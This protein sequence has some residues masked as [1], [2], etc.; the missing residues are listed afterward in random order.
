MNL[1]KL[2]RAFR[3]EEQCRRHLE[4]MRWPHGPRCPKCEAGAWRLSKR[5]LYE[6]SV[7]HYQFSVLKGTI[8][9]RTHL[10]LTI[11]FKVIYLMT[12]SKKGISACQIKRMFGIHYRT[13]WYLCHRIRTAMRTSDIAEKLMGVLEMD[14]TYVGGK[15]KGVGPG[16][17]GAKSKKTPVLGI[18]ERGGR[19]RCKAV[20][21]VSKAEVLRFAQREMNED[22]VEVL[23]TDEFRSYRI[24]SKIVPH[25]VINHQISYVEG[26]IHTNTVENFWSL[27]KR[28]V[29]GS[30]HHVSAK[31]L[32]RYLDEFMW[33]FNHR[34]NG[35]ILE[36]L[37]GNCER[38]H[39]KYAELVA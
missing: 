1:L 7:C 6:C 23:Y 25:K 34:K 35:D 8:F 36:L 18:I 29:M 14:D 39:V 12:E 13:A 20:P 24:F 3:S 32:S 2:E 33:Q 9:E 11:W 19:I 17:P 38:R 26:D 27:L 31:H 15:E 28:G 10:P 16:R 22:A 4:K 21:N 5:W 30:F 37:L